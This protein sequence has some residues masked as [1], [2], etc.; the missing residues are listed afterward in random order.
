MDRMRL[1]LKTVIRLLVAGVACGLMLTLLVWNGSD[2]S[3]TSLCQVEVLKGARP[4]YSVGGTL[5]GLEGLQEHLRRLVAHA[6]RD[7]EGLSTLY[8]E[9]TAS[10]QTPYGGVREAM[11]ACSKAGA[12]RVF[13]RERGEVACARIYRDRT[14]PPFNESTFLDHPYTIPIHVKASWPGDVSWSV[15]YHPKTGPD[16]VASTVH[17]RV[18]RSGT[19]VE[20]NIEDDVPFGEAFATLKALRAV[21]AD[22]V[23]PFISVAAPPRPDNPWWKGMRDA[24]RDV[25]KGQLTIISYGLPG[26]MAFFYWEALLLKKYGVIS[27]HRG[28]VVEVDEDAYA[29]GYNHVS[30]AGMLNRFGVD[31]EAKCQQ[32]AEA[33]ERGEKPELLEELRSDEET[34]WMVPR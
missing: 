9:I 26:S 25:A 24:R 17:D 20:L 11:A 34:R 2:R 1:P 33:I 29:V 10:A 13:W 28:C 31:V 21:P 14:P 19:M 22:V 12:W 15:H 32:D 5:C 4:R 18:K 27:D 8:V 30:R 7:H 6:P 3:H 23:M 16:D